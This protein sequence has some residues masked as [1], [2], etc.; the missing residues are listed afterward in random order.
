M[1]A[2]ATNQPTAAEPTIQDFEASLQQLKDMVARLETGNLSLADSL[3]AF[4]KAS[5]LAEQCEQQLAKADEQVRII[6]ESMQKN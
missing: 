1:T 6:T 3:E 5:Q 2:A 4:Q